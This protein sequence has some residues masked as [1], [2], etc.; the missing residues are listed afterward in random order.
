MHKSP[1]HTHPGTITCLPEREI[2]A[3]LLLEHLRHSIRMRRIR[4]AGRF[5]LR[6]QPGKEKVQ[7]TLFILK[8]ID[9]QITY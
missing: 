2:V 4:G 5:R 8:F 6:L 3:E 1:R 7:D 9:I